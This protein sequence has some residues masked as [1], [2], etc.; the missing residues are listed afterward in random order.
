MPLILK[1]SILLTTV[2]L[3]LFGCRRYTEQ[4]IMCEVTVHFELPEGLEPDRL[5]IEFEGTNINNKWMVSDKSIS[6][7]EVH[8]RVVRGVYILLA[9]GSAVYT[10]E[11][12]PLSVRLRGYMENVHLLGEKG[13]VTVKLQELY[14]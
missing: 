5:H 12:K 13:E 8:L 2:F 9:E 1:Y 4:D 3:L 7:T 14:I 11:G 6:T 10:Q